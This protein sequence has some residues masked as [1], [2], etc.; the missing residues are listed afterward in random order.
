MNSL[1]D[2]S[3][4]S[5]EASQLKGKSRVSCYNS[6]GQVSIK[7]SKPV[8]SCGQSVVKLK[9]QTDPG[10]VICC[11]SIERAYHLS[12]REAFNQK[13]GENQ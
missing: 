10:S 5:V 6:N 12:E 8:C 4:D 13:E 11:Q 9:S 3:V 2:L 7:D 1:S